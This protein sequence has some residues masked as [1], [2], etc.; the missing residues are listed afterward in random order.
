MN[1]DERI[2]R[3]FLC[4][5]RPLRNKGLGSVKPVFFT[6]RE[7]EKLLIPKARRVITLP[8]YQLH[9]EL[10]SIDGISRKYVQPKMTVVDV[11]ANIGY[12]TLLLS[13]LVGSKGM[14][15]AFEPENRNYNA[16]RH[17]MQLNNVSNIL[18]YQSAVGKVDEICTLYVSSEESGEHSLV[19]KRHC[20]TTQTVKVVRLDD[21]V[22]NVDVIKTDT[23]GNDLHVLQGAGRLLSSQPLL[24][25]EFWPEGI[26]KSGHTCEEFWNLLRSYYQNILIAD[27]VEKTLTIGTMSDA[28]RRIG[29]NMM[30]VNLICSKESL[31]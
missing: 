24:I 23:E 9:L 29:K 12:F 2:F 25:T 31:L 30:S 21:L 14:V 15:F 6:Y 3:L 22:R 27:E 18:V 19:T 11:G 16:L 7:I 1:L 13:K 4:V 28:I 10:S 20:H 5:V 26:I 8:D 17:N